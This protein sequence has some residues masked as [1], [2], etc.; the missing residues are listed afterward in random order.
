[1]WKV[2]IYNKHVLV[3]WFVAWL[4]LLL[5][6]LGLMGKYL[7]LCVSTVLDFTVVLDSKFTSN[8]YL[9]CMKFKVNQWGIFIAF[10]TLCGW[11]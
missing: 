1:M 7:R 11:V 3:A 8:L 4:Y 6:I 5:G 10:L 9:T 2:I